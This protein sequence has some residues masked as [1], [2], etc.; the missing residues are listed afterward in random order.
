MLNIDIN[1]NAGPPPWVL[2]RLLLCHD[3]RY[4]RKDRIEYEPDARFWEGAWL[5][6]DDDASL[7]RLQVCCCDIP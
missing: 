3:L 1:I 2:A 6:A 4:P 5:D 7:A